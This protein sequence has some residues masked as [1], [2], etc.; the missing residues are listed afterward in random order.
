MEAP[1]IEI[2]FFLRLASAFDGTFFIPTKA[3]TLA[4]VTWHSDLSTYICLCHFGTFSVLC[5]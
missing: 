3:N 4:G 2:A 1:A 5:F